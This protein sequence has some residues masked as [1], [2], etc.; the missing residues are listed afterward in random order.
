[1]VL[2]HHD[3]AFVAHIVE[4]FGLVNAT[5]PHAQQVHVRIQRLVNAALKAIAGDAGEQVVVRNP[6]GPLHKHIGAVDAQ[7]E[8]SAILVGRGVDLDGPKPDAA[9]VGGAG[10]TGARE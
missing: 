1:E 10:F 8:R 6:V 3:S 4:V 2:P 9:L 5:A 7:S